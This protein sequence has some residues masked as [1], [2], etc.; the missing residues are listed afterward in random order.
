MAQIDYTIGGK[1]RGFSD[2][3]RANEEFQLKKQLAQI[4]AAESIKAL[5]SDGLSA[6]DLMGFQIQMQNNQANQ[7]IRREQLEST[8]QTQ[9]DR[10]DDKRAV[11][12]EKKDMK[13]R[14][15][16]NLIIGATT[17]IDDQINRID[18]I[19]GKRDDDGNLLLNEQGVPVMPP[20]Q[21]VE[22]NYGFAQ[23]SNKF[24]GTDASN[25]LANLDQ[26]NAASFIQ[27]L[28]EMKNQS[29]TGASGLGSAT[30]REGDKVQAASQ[31]A[32]NREQSFDSAVKNALQYRK[33][34]EASKGRLQSGF[35]NIY[36]EKLPATPN[37]AP[38]PNK[39]REA[40]RKRGIIQ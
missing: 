27:Q 6:K 37:N 2:Y 26:L 19:F 3:Q 24:G 7:D 38:D 33:E 4:Q 9:M 12:D 8:R 31:A 18:R 40:L 10:L 14:N 35:Q 32:A 25:A 21:G 17:T 5:Q 39:A 20:M 23:I 36:K 15:D 30:E 29:A 34:L 16:Q 1:L 28:G 11:L 22:N 13:F